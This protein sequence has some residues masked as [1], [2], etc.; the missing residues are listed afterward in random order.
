MDEKLM[1]RKLRRYMS[2]TGWALLIYYLLMNVAVVL[3]LIIDIAAKGVRGELDLM[4]DVGIS[5]MGNAW[6]Y[7][8]A[9]GLGLLLLFL[10]KKK[11]FC[12]EEL[13][14]QEKP[15][16]GSGF[17][18]ILVVFIGAQ[19][20]FQLFAIV[21]ET[22]LNLLG[23]SA[24]TA[25]ELASDIPDTFSMFLY[26]GLFA[27]VVEE[28][29]FRG[30]L[31]RMMRPYGKLFAIVTTAFLFGMFHGNPVQSPYAF[32]SGIVLGY[33]T[34]E[35]SIGWAMVLH[36]LNNLIL[37][38]TFTRLFQLLPI[39]IGEGINMLLI[40][41]CFLASIVLLICR[42]REIAAYCRE[43]RMHPWCTQA[44]FRAP[45]IICFNV[46]MILSMIACIAVL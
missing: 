43:N 26:V 46:M 40:W 39:G 15:M 31:L 27:P 5:L 38:D 23:L 25:I 10:W 36:M 28:I 42:R 13:W 7:I 1:K 21:L 30:L 45:S 29:L 9:S 22:L 44:F 14:R 3:W 11:R 32:L 33:V 4:E 6:G 20:A 35:Y 8:L 34:V 12:S 41:G 16:S 17:L 19:G 18:T 24:L 37:G 2:K